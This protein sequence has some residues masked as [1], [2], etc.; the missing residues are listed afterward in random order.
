MFFI[1]KKGVLFMYIYRLGNDHDLKDL[2]YLNTE[3][4]RL[5][6]TF[7]GQ[8]I[9][10]DWT[11]AILQINMLKNDVAIHQIETRIDFYE[12]TRKINI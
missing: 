11:E 12:T 6:S 3:D 1:Y 5:F 7:K 2:T 8:K 9:T 4:V 10:L